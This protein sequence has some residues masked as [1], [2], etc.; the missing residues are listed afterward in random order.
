MRMSARKATIWKNW[1]G[2]SLFLLWVPAAVL[3]AEPSPP[4]LSLWSFDQGISNEWGG[5]YN[6][7]QREPSWARTYLDPQVT[8]SNKGHSLR[9]TAHQDSKGFCGAWLDLAGGSKSQDASA[10]PYL[11][12]WIK[13]ERGGEDFEMSLSDD[14]M[15]EDDEPKT[16]LHVRDRLPKGVTTGWQEVLIPIEGFEG[17]DPRRLVRLTLHFTAAG[18]YRF[19]LDDISLKREKSA[20]LAPGA[21]APEVKEAASGSGTNRALWVWKALDLFEAG[22]GQDIDRLFAF[23]SANR[24]REIYLAM[25]FDEKETESGP[26]C[27]LRLPQSYRDFLERA[28][29]Q[30]FLVEGLA[31]T[32]EWALSKNHAEALAAADAALAFNRAAPPGA[33]FDGIHFDV[34]PYLLLGYDDPAFGR[35]VRDEFL[36]MVSLVNARVRSEPNLRFSCDVPSWFYADD[37]PEREEVLAT[38]HGEEKAVGEHLTDMLDSVTIMDY[39]NQ[40]DGAGGI[41]ARGIPALEYAASQG[42][43]ILIGVET[44]LEPERAIYFVGHVK[45]EDFPG[46]LDTT[47][48]G[49]QLYF[50]NFRLVAVSD[51]A[52]SH[53]GLSAPVEMADSQRSEFEGVLVQLARKVNG[54][55]DDEPDPAAAGFE[56]A[57]AALAKDPDWRGFE[58]FEITDPENHPSVR[59]FRSIRRMSPRITFHGLGR[60]VFEEET[61]SS[62]VWLGRFPSFSGLAIHFYDSYRELIEGK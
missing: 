13:G 2:A 49:G 23:C 6:V 12:F 52:T 39:I 56:A 28:H 46:R 5:R 61:Q 35:R 59:G 38:F 26:V 31:G 30:G 25:E 54:G 27:N 18:D 17:T 9:V 14:S 42:K 36:E 33:R 20:R 58:T 57:R 15:G 8:R 22:H 32:A 34:E 19:Y 3:A 21:A 11:S 55:N 40:A 43:K 47:G 50:E 45:K 37:G 60:R 7:Y 44:F 16:T 51:G 53:L 1:A 48:L 10:Y 41:I 24:I 4:A 29:R 62:V